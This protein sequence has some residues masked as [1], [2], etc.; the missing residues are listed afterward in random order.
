MNDKSIFKLVKWS[1]IG[2]IFYILVALAI[3]GYL[4]LLFI[5]KVLI[6]LIEK[7]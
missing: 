5:N 1:V 3:G 7:L 4:G 2:Y 6:P